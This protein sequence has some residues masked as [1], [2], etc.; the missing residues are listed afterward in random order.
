MKTLKTL[1][2][3]LVIALSVVSCGTSEKE[4]QLQLELAQSEKAQLEQAWLDVENEQMAIISSSNIDFQYIVSN[5]MKHDCT[6]SCMINQ[7][8]LV[9][10]IQDLDIRLNDA[11]LDESKHRLDSL[12]VQLEKVDAKISELLLLLS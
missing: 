5:L 6:L 11:K 1:I 8:E 12:S 9:D 3:L 10:I 2:A 7:D 4:L